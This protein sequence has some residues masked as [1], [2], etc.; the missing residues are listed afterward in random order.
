MIVKP[1]RGI[2]EIVLKMSS[3]TGLEE[4][5][6]TGKNM[7]PQQVELSEMLMGLSKLLCILARKIA[8]VPLSTS[9]LPECMNV[10]EDGVER[11]KKRVSRRYWRWVRDCEEILSMKRCPFLREEPAKKIIPSKIG[12][13]LDQIMV[14]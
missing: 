13:S 3:E 4:T 11:E 8:R 14:L 7:R 5:L 9:K 2:R 10:I 12:L 6:I 1:C